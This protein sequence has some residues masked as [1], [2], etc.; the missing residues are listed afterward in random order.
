M[1]LI[2][3]ARDAQVKIKQ[4]IKD[5]TKKHEERIGKAGETAVRH[6]RQSWKRLDCS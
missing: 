3:E 4:K 6:M 5:W 2:S 1:F